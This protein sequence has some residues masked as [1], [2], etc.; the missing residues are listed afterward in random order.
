MTAPDRPARPKLM[1]TRELTDG[2]MARMQDLFDVS[3]HLGA[4]GMT[5]AA[6]EEAVAG[7]DVLVPTIT[8]LIDAGLIAKAGKQLKLIANFGVGVDHIDLSAARAAGII[9][10]NTPGVL[11]EDT[12][13]ITMALILAV[14]RRIGEGE[15]LVRAGQWQ[16][17]Q[18]SFMLGH[19]VTGKRLGIV[20]MG[21]IGRAIARRAQG[22]GLKIAYHNRHRLPES[23]EAEL[24]GAVH[25]ADLDAMLGAID[26]LSINCPHT[27]ETHEMIDARRLALLHAGVTVVNTARGEIIDEDALIAALKSGAIAGAGLDVYVGEPRIDPRFL[28]LSNVVLLPHMGSATYEGRAAMGEKVIANIRAWVDGH[29]PPDQVLEGWV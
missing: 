10:T 20:G 15:R 24:G 25:Y 7:V 4:D 12:A 29:R 6:L 21:R 22:F 2:V 17:W 26:I 16:G 11:T 13:D 5:R 8:D 9:V 14:P 1:V 27:P 3:F 28:E 23:V 18:P 19:R